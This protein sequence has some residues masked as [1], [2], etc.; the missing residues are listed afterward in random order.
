[1]KVEEFEEIENSQEIWDNNFCGETDKVKQ[2][3]CFEYSWV[4]KKETF[5]N[6]KTTAVETK[7]VKKYK[8][9][10]TD[11]LKKLCFEFFMELHENSHM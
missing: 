7:Y 8:I 3:D 1:M 11:K 9:K 10:E 4:K 2:K 5:M 6:E